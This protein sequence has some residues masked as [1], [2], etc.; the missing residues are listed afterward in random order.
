MTPPRASTCLNRGAL[1]A[2]AVIPICAV[3]LAASGQTIEVVPLAGYRFNNDLFEVAANHPIDAD[4]APVLGV[5]L[6][7]ATGDGQWFETLFTRQ[8]T[9]VTLPRIGTGPP[10]PGSRVVVDQALAGG[11][12]EF[13]GGAVRPFFTGL[14][15]LTH[16]A[17]DGNDE[18]RFTIGAGGGVRLPLQRRLGVRLDSR[19]LTTFVDVDA[20]AAACGAGVCVARVNANVVWQF[21]FTADVIVVF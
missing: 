21:E 8:E 3:P 17:A 16:Y 9:D 15:G 19:V 2:L 1:V 7:V 14:L 10:D 4:G 20:R 6:N 13:G 11:R 18:V 5:A 12:Q